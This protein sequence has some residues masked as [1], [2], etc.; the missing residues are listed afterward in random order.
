M[1]YSTYLSVCLATALLTPSPADADDL[2]DSCPKVD[3]V[4][5]PVVDQILEVVE[6]FRQGSVSPGVVAQFEKDLQQATRELA[7]VATQ[8]AYSHLEPIA[9]NASPMEV[10]FEGDSYRRL[11]K[12][13][14]QH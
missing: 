13:T 14:P 3:D 12:K 6:R 2:P 8:W 7:R 10:R 5:G 9:V 4:L 1:S 11:G